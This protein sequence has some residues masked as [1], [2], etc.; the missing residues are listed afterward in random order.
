MRMESF[1]LKVELRDKL[2]WGK[3]LYKVHI[4]TPGVYY[5]S[6]VSDMDEYREEVQKALQLASRYKGWMPRHRANLDSL[7]PENLETIEAVINFRIAFNES[8]KGNDRVEGD[9]ISFYSSDLSLIQAVS[10]IPHV[11]PK[12]FQAD[13]S[14]DGV[15]QF[16]KEPPSKF[17]VYLKSVRIS[18]ELRIEFAEYLEK[19]QS[20]EPSDSLRRWLHRPTVSYPTW[21]Q[22]SYYVNYDNSS[23]YTM[24][25]IKFSELIGK[26]YKLEKKA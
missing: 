17:R 5:T 6:K 2:Y 16:K 14:P 10:N 1:K 7:T 8:K 13:L 25:A 18:S 3:Y 19:T 12:F 21:S 4:K 15:K 23:D 22:S 9:G 20:A 26:N 24:M 11:K